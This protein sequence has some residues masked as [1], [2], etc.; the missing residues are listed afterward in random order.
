MPSSHQGDP[1]PGRRAGA[2]PDDTGR[3]HAP[4]NAVVPL[5]HEDTPEKYGVKPRGLLR[6]QDQPHRV[7]QP[8]ATAPYS[9]RGRRW[10]PRHRPRGPPA[11]DAQRLLYHPTY[12][13]SPA[14]GAVTRAAV[15]AGMAPKSSTRRCVGVGTVGQDPRIRARHGMHT[16]DRAQPG[17]H[18]WS[19]EHDSA[20]GASGSPPS[21]SARSSVCA[22]RR[23][24]TARS[25]P[26]HGATSEGTRSTPRCPP[27]SATLDGIRWTTPVD[28]APP[29]GTF[30]SLRL[31]ARN[32][33]EH[34]RRSSQNREHRGIS[35]RRAARRRRDAAL[36]QTSDYLL[37]AHSWTP[38]YSPA[39]AGNRLYFPGAGARS[40]SATTSI[41]S[42]RPRSDNSP[43]TSL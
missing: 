26:P 33:G 19:W 15:P 31:T 24:S 3:Q 34:R 5:P 30:Y 36:V 2:G 7:P 22:P 27:G 17:V 14:H 39:L 41:P 12:R 13:N 1:V 9:E 18:T 10:R 28:L 23:V 38:S 8:V 37:P 6:M 43:S 42:C 29:S 40:I 4:A 11:D 16:S 35:R 25:Q 32:G 21:F 20:G